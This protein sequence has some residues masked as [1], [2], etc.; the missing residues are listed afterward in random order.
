MPG[1]SL[2]SLPPPHTHAP[3][4]AYSSVPKDFD[5]KKLQLLD[6]R[7]NKLTAGF[8]Q[9]NNQISKLNV[10]G[11]SI[12]ELDVKNLENLQYL[13]CADNGLSLVALGNHPQMQILVARNNSEDGCHLV[14]C[15]G[16]LNA[17]SCYPSR[18]C[19][20]GD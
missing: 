10:R 4:C 19:A 8:S 9:V 5:I 15:Q 7:L 1:L 3:S 14:E 17:C 18:H 11:N 20:I 6:L 2:A 16:A 12:T 13:N